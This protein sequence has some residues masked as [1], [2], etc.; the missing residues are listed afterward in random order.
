M[1]VWFEDK[2]P[3]NR[4]G[5]RV[6]FGW[7]DFREKSVRGPK[8]KEKGVF[9]AMTETEILDALDS[10]ERELKLAVRKPE[11]SAENAK[12]NTTHCEAN[13]PIILTARYVKEGKIIYFVV[14]NSEKDVDLSWE[15]TGKEKAQLWNPSE[16]SVCDIR[17]DELFR[18]VSYRGSF[19]VFEN[20]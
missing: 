8:C 7:Y 4:V 9:R 15:F 16:G 5:D 20:E 1:N 19:L 12:N 6:R 10:Q 17:K 3:A 2:L 18:L 13:D 11:A 14:N